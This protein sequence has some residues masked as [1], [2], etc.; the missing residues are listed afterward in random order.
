[1]V[2]GALEADR[3]ELAPAQIPQQVVRG[4]FEVDVPARAQGAPPPADRL[5]QRDRAGRVR[6]IRR[7]RGDDPLRL[8][9]EAV[10]AIEQRRITRRQEARGPA[11][12]LDR[13][14]GRLADRTA[15]REASSRFLVVEARPE[16]ARRVEDR[17]VALELDALALARDGGLVADLRDAPA[18]EGIDEGRLP[19]V[20]DP[21]D[22][23]AQRAS[24]SAAMGRELAAASRHA[25]HAR[26]LGHH[27]RERRRTQSGLRPR[28]LPGAGDLRVREIRPGHDREDGLAA[29]QLFEERVPARDR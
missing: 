10:A 26:P 19:D 22:H 23:R 3:P 11:R 12:H 1:V 17:E 18:A 24:R 28:R 20:R 5:E 14:V 2:L 27:E 16:H 7:G 21:D 8:A 9:L 6:G 4:T 25:A 15:G 13:V 29:R